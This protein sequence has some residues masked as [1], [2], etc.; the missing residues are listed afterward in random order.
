MK[1][2]HLVEKL[3]QMRRTGEP[4]KRLTAMTHLFGIIFAEDI[5]RSG[6]NAT[7]IARKAGHEGWNVEIKNGQNLADYV[8]V[9]PEH[10]KRWRNEGCRFR[11]LRHALG[12]QRR[13]VKAHGERALGK[14]LI[15]VAKLW[16]VAGRPSQTGANRPFHVLSVPRRCPSSR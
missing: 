4:D 6:T 8:V 12:R 5:R 10:L 1:K 7:E 15:F 3:K 16:R 9:K 2:C 14:G 13:R 11:T